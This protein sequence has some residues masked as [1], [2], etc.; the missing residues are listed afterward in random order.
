MSTGPAVDTAAQGLFTWKNAPA[1][2]FYT[3]D[4][5]NVRGNEVAVLS[6]H[7]LI[8]K[9]HWEQELE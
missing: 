6:R 2:E 8:D 7:E 1:G 9:A 5:V 4:V 3:V